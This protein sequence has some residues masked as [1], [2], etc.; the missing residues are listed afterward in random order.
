VAE[1][2]QAA[3]RQPVWLNG[4][5]VTWLDCVELNLGLIGNILRVRTALKNLLVGV[6]FCVAV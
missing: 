6:E 5:T 3:N 1:N 4:R 2:S